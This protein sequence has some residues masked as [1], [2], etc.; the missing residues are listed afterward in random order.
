MKTRQETLAAKVASQ[1]M[2]SAEAVP[3]V[4]APAP[5]PVAP[6]E[7][8]PVPAPE[9]KILSH[10]E[11]A[12]ACQPLLPE[13]AQIEKEMCVY[14]VGAEMFAQRCKMNEAG[15]MALEGSPMKVQSVE[16]VAAPVVATPAAPPAPEANAEVESLKAQLAAR[17]RDLAEAQAAIAKADTDAKDAAFASSG[18]KVDI[19]PLVKGAASR[20][21]G[22]TWQQA[23]ARIQVE[24]PS[25]FEPKQDANASTGPIEIGRQ[26]HLP[27]GVGMGS[28]MTETAGTEPARADTQEARKANASARNM[29]IRN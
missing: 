21:D 23:V 2:G 22:E 18:V 1:L 25:A 27:Q 14:S 19:A 16:P 8:A 6:A 5:P 15:A 9:V 7:P 20:K 13:G 12:A 10:D 11:W 17:D 4:A 28:R 29:Q 3:A 26:R 24:M